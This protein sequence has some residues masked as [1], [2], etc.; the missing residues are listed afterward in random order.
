MTPKMEEAKFSDVI[1]VSNPIIFLCMIFITRLNMCFE[2][3]F[4]SS[5]ALQPFGLIP[6]WKYDFGSQ[7]KA[8]KSSRGNC[9]IFR[10]NS[11]SFNTAL[12]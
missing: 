4:V 10:H 5:G 3:V 8:V 9:A 6:C 11:T 12:M 1:D 7:R 2:M